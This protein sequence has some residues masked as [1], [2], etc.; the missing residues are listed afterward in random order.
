MKKISMTIVS[1]L[2]AGIF[3]FAGGSK[4]SAGKNLVEVRIG[5]HANEGGAP[6]AAVAKEQGFFENTVLNPYLLSLK[7]APPK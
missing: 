3:L 2:C 4:E 6:L 7:A 1:V 5:I